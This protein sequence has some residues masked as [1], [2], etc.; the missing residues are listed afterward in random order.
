MTPR[1]WLQ[2]P[3]GKQNSNRGN[4]LVQGRKN[5]GEP[6][7]GKTRLDG[8]TWDMGNGPQQRTWTRE[9]NTVIHCNG[10][11]NGCTGD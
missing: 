8:C 5:R 1:T 3:R 10:S 4:R 7:H 2:I 9:G 11:Q 6:I